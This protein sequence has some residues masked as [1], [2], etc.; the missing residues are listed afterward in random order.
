[1]KQ[2]D[3]YVEKLTVGSLGTNCYLVYD[4]NK[5][6][7]IIDP[8]DDADYIASVIL[9]K[10]IKPKLIIVTHG[11]FDHILAAE[12][13]KLVFNIPIA[14]SSKDEFLIKSADSR[15]KY[16]NQKDVINLGILSI[17]IDLDKRIDINIGN[18]K[19]SL[20]KT[21]GHTPGSISLYLKKENIIFVGDL[22]FANGELGRTDF[23]YGD[24]NLLNL[25][26]KK[27]RALSDDLTIFSGH[28]EIW[29]INE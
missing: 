23:S 18:I 25:S 20:I 26:I 15:A 17:D 27:I 12:E 7:V 22:I 9:Q 29:Q 8:G 4:K 5:E 10:S 2:G 14:V 24:N 1:M 3:T 21:P 28:G 6:G 13:L 19:F 11:H 16:F